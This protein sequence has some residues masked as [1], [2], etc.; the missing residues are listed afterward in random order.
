MA[1][2]KE[3]N[4]SYFFF[5]MYIYTY[6]NSIEMIGRSYFC[7]LFAI[8]IFSNLLLIPFFSFQSYATVKMLLHPKIGNSMN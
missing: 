4:I 6:N 5:A 8:H 3:K 1:A 7:F 2:A